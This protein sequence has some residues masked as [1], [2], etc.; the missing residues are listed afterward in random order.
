MCCVGDVTILK[1]ENGITSISAKIP[2]DI[3]HPII[4]ELELSARKYGLD[5]VKMR[6]SMKD[7]PF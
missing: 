4:T 6:E 2:K 7:I 5:V 1:V 3:S